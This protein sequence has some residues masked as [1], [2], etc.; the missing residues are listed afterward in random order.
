MIPV[1]TDLDLVVQEVTT[2]FKRGTMELLLLSLLSVQDMYAYELSKELK[3]VSVGLF[4]VQGPSLYTAL[5]RLESRGF[6]STWT[7]T[8]GKRPRIYYHI[9]PTGRKFLKLLTQEY[10]SIQQGIRNVLEATGTDKQTGG[11]D[12]CADECE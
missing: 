7:E 11:K 10:H 3:R 8:V 6:V 4:D 1:N 2:N 5:Y 12:W 9:Q